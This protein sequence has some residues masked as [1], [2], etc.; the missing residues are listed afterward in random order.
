MNATGEA[1]SSGLSCIAHASTAGAVSERKPAIMAV[2]LRER[3]ARQGQRK[4]QGADAERDVRVLRR[5]HVGWRSAWYS[6][7]L[8][9]RNLGR[10]YRSRLRE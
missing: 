9:K 2:V 3:R 5:V 10:V 7:F 6:G 1:C 8:G 4:R